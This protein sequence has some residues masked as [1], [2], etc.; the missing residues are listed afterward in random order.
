MSSSTVASYSSTLVDA[1][2]FSLVGFG[3]GFLFGGFFG[4]LDNPTLIDPRL[5]N[6]SVREQ[7]KAQWRHMASRSWSMAKSFGSVGV[8]YSAVECLMEKVRFSRVLP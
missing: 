5:E 6:A 4:S 3:V 1:C 2:F 7:M 8:V